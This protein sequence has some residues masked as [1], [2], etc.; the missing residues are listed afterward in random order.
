VTLK[1]HDIDAAAGRAAGSQ[2]IASLIYELGFL[3]AV[4]RTG[5]TLAGVRTPETVAEHSHRTAAIAFLL[6]TLAGVDAGRVA[7][8]AVFH[9]FA[10][11][12]TGDIPS[13][14]K[15]YVAKVPDTEI[16]CA[17]V[18]AAP[19]EVQDAVVGLIEEYREQRTL[20]ARLAHD[21]D[22]IE[23]LAQALEYVANGYAQAQ[24]WVQ[25]SYESVGTDVGRQVAS[26][27]L[28]SEPGDWWHDFVSSYRRPLPPA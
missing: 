16:T 28:A 8:L 17:Q 14:G 5:W 21:A 26:A 22:K 1:T 7:A 18:A 12:R 23:C 6:A 19:I 10:E 25:G 20:A 3:K 11:T 9:D 27:I 13:V 2:G 15:P 24:L 4:P